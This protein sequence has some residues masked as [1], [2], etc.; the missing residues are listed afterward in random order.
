MDFA[1]VWDPVAGVGDW[2]MTGGD[3]SSDAGLRTAVVLSLLSD[4]TLRDD[5]E[6]PAS[7][8]RGGWWGDLVL[9]GDRLGDRFGSRLRLLAR[10][11]T[12]DQTRRRAVLICREALAWLIEDGIARSVDVTAEF[13]G[14]RGEQLHIAVTVNRAAPAGVARIDVLWTVEGAR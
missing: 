11:L 6:L 7:G 5:D 2:Q 14:D 1:T 4:A 8:D 3:L 9:E 10:S 12:G 13:A